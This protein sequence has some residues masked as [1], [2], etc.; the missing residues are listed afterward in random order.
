M[1]LVFVFQR[2]VK[3]IYPDESVEKPENKAQYFRRGNKGLFTNDSEAKAE[4]LTVVRDTYRP[5]QKLPIRQRGQ[6]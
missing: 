1:F 2:V 6:F 5:P 4:S 3:S